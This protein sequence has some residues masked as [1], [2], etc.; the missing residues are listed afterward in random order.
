MSPMS[1]G[2]MSLIENSILKLSV[3]ERRKLVSRLSERLEQESAELSKFEFELA[4]MAK[5]EDIQREIR[6]IELDF[7]AAEFDG[8][9]E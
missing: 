4:E 6:A 7:R 2:T 5:D 3:E 1:N 8:L 9:A